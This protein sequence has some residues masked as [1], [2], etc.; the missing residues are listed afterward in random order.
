MPR[1]SQ[2]EM[3]TGRQTASYIRRLLNRT[4]SSNVL[5]T[6]DRLE[7]LNIELDAR[8]VA[9]LCGVLRETLY[10]IRDAFREAV[11]AARARDR[12]E[13]DEEGEET[14]NESIAPSLAAAI[15]IPIVDDATFTQ[16]GLE[17]TLAAPIVRPRITVAAARGDN[18]RPPPAAPSGSHPY[19]Y[20]EEL[21]LGCKQLERRYLVLHY[22]QSV[23]HTAIQERLTRDLA[24][25]VSYRIARAS[26]G[27]VV[28]FLQYQ[29]RVK[30]SGP[31]SYTIAGRSPKVFSVTPQQREGVTRYLDSC[32]QLAVHPAP[33]VH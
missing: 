6:L 5:T 10:E 25:T 3:L 14:D 23:P 31:V 8:Q 30:S 19:L 18:Q 17:S 24:K 32:S 26:D 7:S 28:A 29:G 2:P 12:E 15:D 11:M 16:A 27:A 22:D 21:P 13:A 33:V 4:S 1:H 20:Q 9:L